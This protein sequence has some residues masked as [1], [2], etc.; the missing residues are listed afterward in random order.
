[1]KTRLLPLLSALVLVA[2]TGCSSFMKS[3]TTR[4]EDLP[5]DRPKIV[6]PAPVE[7]AVQVFDTP[8]VAAPEPTPAPAPAA[9]PVAEVV[10]PAQDQR[11]VYYDF[12]GTQLRD[13]AQAVVAGNGNYLVANP[14]IKIRVEGHT[15]QRG[16]REY[17]L[18]LGQR[19]ADSLA[20]ALHA[21]GVQGANIE[22]V[23]YGKEKPANAARNEQGYAVNRQADIAYQNK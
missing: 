13:D 5:P 3:S 14:G 7:P 20:K 17:N 16:S 15:D 6:R 2:L 19:R 8:V 18:A 23:S 1:M 12:D 10:R 22:T 11:S 21:M 4:E 9:A